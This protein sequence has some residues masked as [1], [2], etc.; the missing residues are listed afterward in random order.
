MLVVNFTLFRFSLLNLLFI[1][2]ST[3]ESL[4]FQFLI[5]LSTALVAAFFSSLVSQPGDTL[6]SAVNKSVN[7]PTEIAAIGSKKV[8]VFMVMKDA[9]IK[10]GLNGLF[11]GTKARLL[12][13][14]FFVSVQ[15]LVYDFVKQ[16]C[17]I[18]VTGI[19]H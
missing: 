18:P 5:T 8:N 9:T 19:H 1:G 13:V 3:E 15:L 12:H 6:L 16:L 2:Y 14:S 7:Y 4:K 10:G 17:G 11:V